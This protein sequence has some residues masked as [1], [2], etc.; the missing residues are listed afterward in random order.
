MKNGTASNS[1]IN[2]RLEQMAVAGTSREDA[3]KGVCVCQLRFKE[4]GCLSGRSSLTLG[5]FP[6]GLQLPVPLILPAGTEIKNQ[7]G[8]IGHALMAL[9]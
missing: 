5:S 3:G 2:R 1:G 6:S 9:K 7:I 8:H 4:D